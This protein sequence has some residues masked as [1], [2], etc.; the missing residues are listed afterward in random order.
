V[1]AIAVAAGM[2]FSLVLTEGGRVFSCGDDM[3]VTFSL[4]YDYVSD[5][6][7]LMCSACTANLV[8]ATAAAAQALLPFLN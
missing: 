5:C 2:D 3:F 7:H 6:R 1:Q 8:E 4:R